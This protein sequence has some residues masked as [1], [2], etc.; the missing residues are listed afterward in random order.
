MP[1]QRFTH[2]R[3][4]PA[5]IG[6]LFRWWQ[7]EHGGTIRDLARSLKVTPATVYYWAGKGMPYRNAKKI[8]ELT[9]GVFSLRRLFPTLKE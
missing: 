6:D 2:I 1:T 9:G 5:V 4:D 8:V 7:Y 3:T